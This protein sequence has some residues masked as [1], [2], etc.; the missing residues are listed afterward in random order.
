[1]TYT[2]VGPQGPNQK[3]GRNKGVMRE[4]RAQKR[5]EA[6]AR[7]AELPADSP[8]R[9]RNRLAQPDYELAA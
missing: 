1:M 6:E 4:R 2:F 7:D 3:Y 9:R 5:I 8:R